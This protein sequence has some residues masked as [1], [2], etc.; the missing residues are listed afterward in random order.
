MT[1][2]H[3][4]SL[5]LASSEKKSRKGLIIGWLAISGRKELG[6]EIIQP[7]VMNL[8]EAI[9]YVKTQ[10]ESRFSRRRIT[11]PRATNSRS[12]GAEASS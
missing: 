8:S 12:P 10:A 11:A 3:R 9:A 4:R 6:L 7:D 5:Q 1:A 2:V